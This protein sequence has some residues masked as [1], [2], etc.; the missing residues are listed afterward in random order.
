MSRKLTFY[1]LSNLHKYSDLQLPIVINYLELYEPKNDQEII[2]ILTGLEPK[3][4]SSNSATVLA[5]SK[6]FIKMGKLK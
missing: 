6:V 1:L 3:L 2:D 4:K 5:I